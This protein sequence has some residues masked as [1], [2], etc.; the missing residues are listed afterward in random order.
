MLP[1]CPASDE[2]LTM[3]PVP[4]SSMCGRTA[5]D[6]KKGAGQ[7]DRQHL[8]PVLVGHLQNGAVDRDAGVIDEDVQ[9]AVAVD[10]L[11][12]RAPAVL[13]RADVAL[14]DSGR[15]AMDREAGE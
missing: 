2:M 14:V 11:A 9:A 15:H 7:V 4:R 12:H 10:D 6:M 1:I 8:V 3:R 5:F 13:G